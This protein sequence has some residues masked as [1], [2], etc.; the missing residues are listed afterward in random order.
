[1]TNTRAFFGLIAL[2]ASLVVSACATGPQVGVRGSYKQKNIRATT[3]V[4]FF[5][6]SRFSL[7]AETVDRRLLWAQTAAVDW[8]DERGVRVTPPDRARGR[9][10]DA[11]LWRHFTGGG[12]LRRNLAKSFESADRDQRTSSQT[13]IVRQIRAESG[14]E[15]RFLLF[16]ELLYHSAGTCQARAD[17]HTERSDVVVADDAPD[18]R[19]RPCIVTHFQARLVDADSGSTVWYNRRMREWHVADAGDAEERRN[20]EEVVR[21]ALGGGDGLA[22]VLGKDT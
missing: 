14:L 1:M 11:S 2:V 16:G 22:D 13:E 20:I 10:R 4:P 15:S 21:E 3:V 7:A 19:P 9:L 8:L 12:L 6:R 17:D 18:T 5:T